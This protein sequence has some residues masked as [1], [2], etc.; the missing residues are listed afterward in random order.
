VLFAEAL[1]NYVVIHTKDK[2]HITYLTFKAVE[3]YLPSGQFIKIHKSYI[4]SASKIESI[5]GNIIHIGKQQLPVS[6]NLKDEV[7]EKLLKGKFLKR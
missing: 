1:Q 3:D 4:V 2:K 7:M 6:R 5:E